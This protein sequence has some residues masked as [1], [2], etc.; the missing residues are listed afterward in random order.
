MS[1]LL[2]TIQGKRAIGETGVKALKK[3]KKAKNVLGRAS[4][5]SANIRGLRQGRGS[6]TFDSMKN[7]KKN[8]P[9]RAGGHGEMGKESSLK[10]TNRVHKT[11]SDMKKAASLK[12]QLTN[13]AVA[14]GVTV[15]GTALV[16]GASKLKKKLDTEKQWKRLKERRPELTSTQ[17]DRENFEVLQDFSPDIAS[18][19]TTLET[20]M[21]RVNRQDMIPHEFVGDL[22][23]TQRTVDQGSLGR[24]LEEAA[25]RSA[26]KGMDM[27]QRSHQFG[28]KQDLEREKFDASKSQFE[29]K[30]RENKRQFGLKHKLDRRRAADSIMG[31][32]MDELR[33]REQGVSPRDLYQARD[34][35]RR[36]QDS[37]MRKMSNLQSFRE[38]SATEEQVNEIDSIEPITEYVKKPSEKF[39]K[40][41][42][43]DVKTRLKT[44]MLKVDEE[45]NHV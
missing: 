8:N 12:D 36:S 30:H 11:Y 39:E 26:L 32:S 45:A 2:S 41:P 3:G 28:Q 34:R 15:G 6:K 18:N 27:G 35:T 10:I 37:I 9:H 23:N 22:A 17:K 5:H 19:I 38:S 31:T 7:K 25:P 1:F 40:K 29:D 33:L 43:S 44:A 14:T 42:F 16:R 4:M 24:Q 20:Y 13:A 21:D